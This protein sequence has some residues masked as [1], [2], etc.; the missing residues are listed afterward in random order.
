MRSG[1]G[2]D[3]LRELATAA[4][5]AGR[6]SSPARARLRA[7]ALDLL[8]RERLLD[9]AWSYR[10]APLEAPAAE[11]LH[12]GGETLVAPMLLPDSGV[13]TAL[14]CAVCTIGPALERRV[15][16]LFGERRASLAVA[17]DE[18]GNEALFAVSRALQDRILADV[19]RSGRSMAGE[20]RAG[21]P[22]LDLSTQGAVAR[23][24]GAAAI[25]VLV[26]PGALLDPLK[27]TSMVFGVGTDL[28][29]TPWSRCDSCP[30][31]E[32]CRIVAMRAAAPPSPEAFAN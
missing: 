26:T 14:A 18:L 23:L 22:G 12:V 24:S 7:Q 32:R 19:R 25:G 27:S 30:S 3:P 21:D 8:R 13:L 4:P 10:I 28:P 16:A 11:R 2:P 15:R 29:E 1:R 5:A 31:R 20:L 6:A 17:L 9:A